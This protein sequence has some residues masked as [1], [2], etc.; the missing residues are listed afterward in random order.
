LEIIHSARAGR[1]LDGAIGSLEMLPEIVAAV[2]CEL[3]VLFDSGIRTGADIVK[4]LALG[5]KAVLIGRP[6]V[7]GL[8]VAGKEG[9]KAVLQG[10]LADF[11]QSLALTG[12]ESIK[13]CNINTIRKVNYGGDANSSN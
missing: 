10:L 1:Q 4:A 9:A 7:Y 6:V 2:G 12:I 11:D 5:A 3:T 13:D 8:A